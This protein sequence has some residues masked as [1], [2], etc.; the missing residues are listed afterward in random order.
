[1]NI[2]AVLDHIAKIND[3]WV[4]TD[5]IEVYE[6]LVWG[7]DNETTKPTLQE[8]E[9]IWNEIIIT[10]PMELLRSNRDK[11][12]VECDWVVIRAYSQGVAVPTEWSTYMQTLRDLP[13]T[14]T[15]KLDSN[16]MVITNTEIFP[17]KPT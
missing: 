4:Y 16:L 3:S 17:T 12:L 2:R 6:N 11:M 14:V 9:D 8:C 1:M 15:P 7:E 13:A 5:D 10:Q